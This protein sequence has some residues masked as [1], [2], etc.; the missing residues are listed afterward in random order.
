[1]KENA[2]KLLYLSDQDIKDL[3]EQITDILGHYFGDI[4]LES[5]MPSKMLYA[6]KNLHDVLYETFNIDFD[7]IKQV[8][9]MAD[10]RK[11]AQLEQIKKKKEADE[12][13]GEELALNKMQIQSDQS[14]TVQT[15]KTP[16]M[17]MDEGRENQN[18]HGNDEDIGNDM[19]LEGV[20]K[21]ATTK[22]QSQSVK[23]SLTLEPTPEN[24]EKFL[25]GKTPFFQTLALKTALSS[26][27]FIPFRKEMLEKQKKA[28]DN[29]GARTLEFRKIT[30]LRNA[31]NGLNEIFKQKVLEDLVQEFRNL[32]MRAEKIEDSPEIEILKVLIPHLKS[33]QTR[34]H[35]L[36]ATMLTLSQIRSTRV[37]RIL[38]RRYRK[39]PKKDPIKDEKIISKITIKK[40]GLDF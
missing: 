8:G 17:D 7:K 20:E 35:E 39:W 2:R 21:E 18:A 36:L 23:P 10:S 3:G 25:K 14:P 4:E 1:M 37:R 22:P 9:R 16:P 6:S 5:N 13:A 24:F 29:Q 28:I 27:Q 32:A 19:A 33:E 40:F 12:K 26:N 15:E 38:E 34:Q 11:L 31:G 30:S